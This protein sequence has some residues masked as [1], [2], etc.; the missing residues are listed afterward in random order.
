MQLRERVCLGRWVCGSIVG[1]SVFTTSGRVCVGM[2]ACWEEL[3]VCVCV[4]VQYSRQFL[5]GPTLIL[6]FFKAM[7]VQQLRH[8]GPELLH[9]PVQLI[10]TEHANLIIFDNSPLGSLDFV[11]SRFKWTVRVLQIIYCLLVGLA[12]CFSSSKKTFSAQSGRLAKVDTLSLFM[13]IGR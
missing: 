8:R 11:F 12:F 3:R 13:T 7:L 1:H 9:F 5:F 6:Q 10:K 2:C 4:C